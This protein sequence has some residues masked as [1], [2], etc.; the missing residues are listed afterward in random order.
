MDLLAERDRMQGDGRAA[1][2]RRGYAD[3]VREAQSRRWWT[4]A[5]A[6]EQADR[7]WVRNWAPSVV[8][9]SADH[10]GYL[11]NRGADAAY[12]DGLRIARAELREVIEDARGRS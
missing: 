7:K 6:E 3:G 2:W 11:R 1:A 8:A 9:L 12:Q 4:D 10:V 5:P